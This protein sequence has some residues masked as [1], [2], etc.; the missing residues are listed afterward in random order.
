MYQT[1]WTPL[2]FAARL[3]YT[4]I[5]KILIEYGG[6]VNGPNNMIQGTEIPKF[7][8]DLKICLITY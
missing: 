4:R 1:G 5:A 2:M 3:G 8:P 6:D 7:T